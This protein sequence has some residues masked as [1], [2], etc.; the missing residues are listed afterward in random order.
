MFRPLRWL[1]AAALL[2]SAALAPARDDP[3]APPKAPPK[4]RLATQPHTSYHAR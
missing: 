3:K 1:C 4:A 2:A